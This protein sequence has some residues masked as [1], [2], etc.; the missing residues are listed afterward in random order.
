LN[1]SGL[2]NGLPRLIKPWPDWGQANGLSRGATYAAVDRM[3]PGVRIKIGGR[4]R[5]NADKLR[6]YLEAG[7]DLARQCSDGPGDS[8]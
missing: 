6:E 8:R 1:N 3:P 7:G 4:L 2:L 5:L